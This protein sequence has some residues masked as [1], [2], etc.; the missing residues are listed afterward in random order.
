VTTGRER[1]PPILFWSGGK[2]SLLAYD[3]VRAERPV[4]L[5]SFDPATGIVP[6]QEIPMAAIRAQAAALG[7]P[8]IEVPL[9]QPCPNE[10]YLAALHAAIGAAPSLVFGDLHLADIRVWREASFAGWSCR[11]PLWQAPYA[12]LLGRLWQLGAPVSVSAVRRDLAARVAV[13][14]RYDPAFVVGLP[15]EVDA[16]GECGEFHTKVSL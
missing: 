10:R 11:F 3:A 7:R 4:L 1:K 14:A 13:G 15:V 5:T 2:D 16:M 9:A 8:L 12:R 6:H